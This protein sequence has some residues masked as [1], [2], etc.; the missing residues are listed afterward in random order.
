M[1]EMLHQRPVILIADDSLFNRALLADM[2]SDEYT[3]VQAQD[4]L[5]ALD[6]IKEYG[7][8]L[9]LVLLDIVMP[10]LDGFGVLEE[11]NRSHWIEDIPVIMISSENGADPI[12]R[13]F[14]LGATDFINRPYDPL[15]VHKRVVNTILLYTKQKQLVSL[16]TQQVYEKE[17]NSNLMIEVLGHI[18]E[19]RNRES[20]LHIRHVH[21]ITE[22]V[23]KHLNR[24]GVTHYSEAEIA[25]ISSASA[26]HDVGKISIP[27]EILNKPGR[28][29][30]EEFRVMKTHTTIGARMLEELP[31]YQDQPMVRTAY[32]IC[33]WHHE[34]TTAGAT[35]TV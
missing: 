6:R 28:L 8:R 15:I 24:K 31:M 34:R 25:L 18:V 14:A 35:P 32:E 3:I 4:G 17:A 23:L 26:L 16:V 29:T 19:F 21:V 30:P 20:G 9:S 12:E 11:M 10:G 1:D 27:E 2:L 5:E 13:A 22:L 7:T 33:R